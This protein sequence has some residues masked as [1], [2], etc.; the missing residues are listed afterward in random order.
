M[1][2]DNFI[3][4][5]GSSRVY[6]GSLSNGREV[7]VKILKQTEDVLNDFVAEIDIITT[8]HHK[9]IIS[10]LGFC[11]EDKNL[12]LVYNYLSRGSLEENLHGTFFNQLLRF[13]YDQGP[14]QK[15][16][17]SN[18]GSKKDMLAFQWRERYK[19]AMGVAEALDYL[20][21]SAS[22]PV[23]HRDVKSSNILLSDDFEPQLSDFGLARWA[24]I[25]TTHMICSDVAGTFGYG[26]VLFF[27]KLMFLESSWLILV[28]IL[29]QLLGS[30]VLHVW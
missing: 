10:L 1:V 12:L 6:R 9:N 2:S 16:L 27:N 22:Q 5:G 7:A 11:V 4:I 19:V 28:F 30:R 26:R 25:S 8:L 3:G 18:S 15:C 23:I 20:H 24:S 29:M 13:N 21:N 17:V 14:K